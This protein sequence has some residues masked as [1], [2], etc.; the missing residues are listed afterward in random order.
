VHGLVVSFLHCERGHFRISTRIWSRLFAFICQLNLL[1]NRF[2]SSS[3]LSDLEKYWGSSGGHGCQRDGRFFGY[4][5][6]TA[7]GMHSIH[8]EYG[9]TSYGLYFNPWINKNT[10]PVV[11]NDEIRYF[12]ISTTF[13]P[14]F[15]KCVHTCQRDNLNIKALHIHF[16]L[17]PRTI[18]MHHLSLGMTTFG[19]ITLL[20]PFHINPRNT[21]MHMSRVT[22]VWKPY[23]YALAWPL[24]R[25]KWS[26]IVKNDDVL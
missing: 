3:Y 1:E 14:Q 11:M 5:I 22:C 18:Q 19:H 6:G 16:L 4:I 25:P 26:P 17:T 21:S 8:F 13:S 12:G 20:P 23:V 7:L 10:L 15:Q 24:V 2:I 9:S